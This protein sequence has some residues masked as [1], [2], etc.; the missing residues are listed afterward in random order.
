M[1]RAK[2]QWRCHHCCSLCCMQIPC[3]SA[4][5]NLAQ[6]CKYVGQAINPGTCHAPDTRTLSTGEERSE[7]KQLGICNMKQ[8]TCNLRQPTCNLRSEKSLRRAQKTYAVHCEKLGA[9][10]LE[11][12]RASW[13]T[14]KFI[15]PLLTRS[16]LP[17]IGS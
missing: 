6:L 1:W 12:L 17:K 13:L 15:L 2:C 10:H 9:A 4:S 8:V 11:E 3:P 16:A 5:S 14:Q 7:T